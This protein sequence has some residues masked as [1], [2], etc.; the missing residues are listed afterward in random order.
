MFLEDVIEFF[1]GLV[2]KVKRCLYVR[3][4]MKAVD[5]A[6]EPYFLC[7]EKES[8]TYGLRAI[9]TFEKINDIEFDPYDWIS[10]KFIHGS[11]HHEAFFRRAKLVLKRN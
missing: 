11:A 7:E 6:R 9:R 10:I 5:H 3:A 2:K 4:M 8:K 1:V